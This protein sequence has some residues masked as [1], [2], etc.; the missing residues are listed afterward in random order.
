[1]SRPRFCSET[2]RS[3]SHLLE[4]SNLLNFHGEKIRS[5]THYTMQQHR[6]RAYILI[7]M[8]RVVVAELKVVHETTVRMFDCEVTFVVHEV[9]DLGFV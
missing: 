7:I 8:H 9:E 1:M 3:L 4:P 5:N 2:R 6:H